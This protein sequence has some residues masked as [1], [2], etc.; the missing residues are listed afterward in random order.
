MEI[1][2][3][4]ETSGDILVRSMVQ[5]ED[6]DGKMP[7]P[8]GDPRHARYNQQHLRSIC[9]NIRD[10]KSFDGSDYSDK[11]QE[12]H[13]EVERQRQEGMLPES[14]SESGSINS[15]QIQ[16]EELAEET[17]HNPA[18]L[19]SNWEGATGGQRSRGSS[20]ERSSHIEDAS[21]VGNTSA[22]ED[23]SAIIDDSAS[24]MIDVSAEKR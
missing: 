11:Y 18:E 21:D 6:L 14:G 5:R 20:R 9:R 13:L 24:I 16:P 4:K 23:G 3:T 12:S 17:I 8:C 10:H 19:F 7:C 22:I 2:R 15:S 1:A